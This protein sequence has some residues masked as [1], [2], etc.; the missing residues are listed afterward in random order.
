MAREDDPRKLS[1]ILN[2]QP[3]L[4]KT[5]IFKIMDV[6]ETK[7]IIPKPHLVS[8]MLDNFPAPQFNFAA[9][10]NVA[11]I[12]SGGNL[13]IEDANR[14]FKEIETTEKRRSFSSI[15]I[16]A[17]PVYQWDKDAEKIINSIDFH[18]ELI[19]LI[20]NNLDLDVSVYMSPAK[21]ANEEGILTKD[22]TTWEK[23]LDAFGTRNTLFIPAYS[24]ADDPVLQ[25]DIENT[26][27]ALGNVAYRL[28]FDTR[29]DE[30]LKPRL[31]WAQE[32]NFYGDGTVIYSLETE[33]KTKTGTRASPESSTMTLI[34]DYL[35]R[36]I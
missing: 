34:Q 2:S 9:L 23:F 19:K 12:K 13:N 5:I 28:I 25:V 21:I 30:A 10:I 32:K 22:P 15:S 26:V 29:D 17:E 24:Y 33:I 1:E 6:S 36:E 18:I 8:E 35:N 31:Q 27:A 14:V 11:A 4:P 3:I 7:E 20:N 16:D